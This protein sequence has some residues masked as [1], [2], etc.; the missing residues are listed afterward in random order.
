MGRYRRQII[1][2]AAQAT[3]RQ[4]LIGTAI[5]IGSIAAM[6][7]GLAA[8]AGGRNWDDLA[9]QS[10]GYVCERA[11]REE[12]GVPAGRNEPVCQCTALRVAAE[13]PTLAGYLSQH[14]ARRQ[15]RAF[16]RDALPVC[17]EATAG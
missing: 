4:W 5:A 7:I 17:R 16:A 1:E 8:F 14:A 2:R 12:D 6:T 3:P 15:A 11:L 10:A 13:R 9:R